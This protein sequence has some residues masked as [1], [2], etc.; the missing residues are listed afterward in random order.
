MGPASGI[1]ALAAALL[2]A[3]RVA[4]TDDRSDRSRVAEENAQRNSLKGRVA[5]GLAG[6]EEPGEKFDLVLANIL[7]NTLVE[8]AGVLSG[9]LA[10]G[11][12]LV[13]SGILVEQAAVVAAAYAPT[14]VEVARESEGDWMLLELQASGV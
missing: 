1:L 2:G 12:R 14:L 9:R 11:G 6:L 7:C 13:L 10:R 4:A 5:F 8:L 3:G